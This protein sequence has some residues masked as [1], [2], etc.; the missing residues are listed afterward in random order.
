MT[1]GLRRV[2][3]MT[4]A[5]VCGLMLALVGT[6]GADEGH[7]KDGCSPSAKGD[8]TAVAPGG[9]PFASPVFDLCKTGPADTDVRGYFKALVTLTGGAI[10]VQGPVTCAAF[11]GKTVSFLYPLNEQS[12]PPLVGTA[13]LVVAKD[14]GPNPAD[15]AVGFAGPLPIAAFGGN[16]CD[17]QTL[18]A[19]VASNI[20][21]LPLG[22]GFITVDDEH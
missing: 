17:L 18:P 3:A 9:V 20:V 2:A 6:S 19:Q 22:S 12:S 21:T 14:G 4:A 15:D 7:G 1:N 16:V 11:D 5:L 8:G 13:I 10:N